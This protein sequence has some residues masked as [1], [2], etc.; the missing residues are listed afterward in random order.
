[1]SRQSE[2]PRHPLSQAARSDADRISETSLHER[3]RPSA[4]CHVCHATQWTL[5]CSSGEIFSQ[6]RQL[7]RFYRRRWHAQPSGTSEDRW[8]F[9]QNYLTSIVA[10]LEC[11]LLYRNPRP[12]PEAITRAYLATR[13]DHESVR[14]EFETQGRWFRSKAG[15]LCGYL[16]VRSRT[17]PRVLE[18]GGGTGGFLAEG[19]ALGWE[20][21]DL[22]PDHALTDLGRR[23]GSAT[24]QSTI[25]DAGWSGETFDA[26]TIWNSFG[27]LSD[28]HPLLNSVVPLIRSGGMLVIRI[29]N[30]ACFEWAMALRAKLPKPWR[31]PLDA[32][33]AWND[34]LT[35]PYLYGYS[36]VGLTSFMSS[37]G[38]TLR[39]CHADTLPSVP[40]ARLKWWAGL[41]E[42]MVKGGCRTACAVSRQPVRG[43]FHLAPWLDVYFE[44]P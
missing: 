6:R 13:N 40:A 31:R 35:F 29:P 15:M 30:G 12:R 4:G 20:M 10:C 8:I 41:E 11:G 42:R 7:E 17:A 14:T 27:Q 34:L 33:L 5:V 19:Q 16:P 32:A 9:T 38:L 44:R 28:P 2:G 25:E 21:L 24:L 18:I 23:R 37:F 43:D 36:P 22:D 26:V 3:P 39:A 1:M